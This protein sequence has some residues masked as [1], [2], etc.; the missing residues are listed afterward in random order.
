[1][2]THFS[3]RLLLPN[4]DLIQQVENDNILTF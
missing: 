2:N 1:M 4:T 3:L